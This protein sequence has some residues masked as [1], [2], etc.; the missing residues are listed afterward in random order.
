MGSRWPPLPALSSKSREMLL[1]HATTRFRISCS[2]Q[3]C[4]DLEPN[5]SEIRERT[6]RRRSNLSATPPVHT[7]AA[8]ASHTP[9]R[10]QLGL[11]FRGADKTGRILWI[12]GSAYRSSLQSRAGS[13]A[14]GVHPP[15]CRVLARSGISGLPEET[16]LVSKKPY[17][18]NLY[19][20]TMV[21]VC[22]EVIVSV[23]VRVRPCAR[24]C[25]RA[26]AWQPESKAKIVT[27]RLSDGWPVTRNP[28]YRNSEMT[29]KESRKPR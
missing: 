1:R 18:V 20:R 29:A 8:A 14:A 7:S 25:V 2:S 4:Q 17:W 24:M 21:W 23:R 10:G 9:R 13:S 28:A 19:T 16:D 15:S 22:S 5:V 27:K 12:G 6:V 11:A 3:Q 26:K